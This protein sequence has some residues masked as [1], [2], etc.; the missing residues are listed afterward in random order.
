MPKAP[1]TAAGAADAMPATDRMAPSSSAAHGQPPTLLFDKVSKWYGPVIGV[2]QVTLE[3]RPGITGLVGSNGAGKSTLLRLASGQICPD[4]G[5]VQVRGK[6]AW[7]AEAKRHIGYCPELDTFYEEM[8]GRRFVET[9]AKMCGYSSREAKRRTEETLEL[10]GMAHRADATV[11]GFSKGMRQRIKLAQALIHDPELL[12]LDEPLSGIDPIG[13][14]ESLELFRELARRG[15]C[16][17]VSS[18]EL[19]ELEKLTDHVAIMA[20]GRI[21]AVGTLTQIRDLLDDHP[22]SIRIASD[23]DR[24]LAAALL[25]FPDV[26]GV[27][28]NNGDG[29]LLRARNPRRFFRQL[30]TLVLEESFDVRHLETLDDSTHAVLGYLLGKRGQ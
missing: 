16:L 17:L 30:S 4:L 21:A 28:L 11:R 23:Q 3:L 27:E 20:R 26:V 15:K 14:R 18:H 5:V 6:D 9:M 13:R 8:T 7:T 24:R 10:V 1:P 22:L 29:L 2:N 19:E 25:D 12:L